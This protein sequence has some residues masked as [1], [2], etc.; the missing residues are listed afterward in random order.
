MLYIDAVPQTSWLVNFI[1]SPLPPSFLSSVHV[2]VFSAMKDI[3]QCTSGCKDLHSYSYLLKT[4]R[5]LFC[6]F[7]FFIIHFLSPFTIRSLSF[8]NPIWFLSSLTTS[9]PIC[10]LIGFDNLIGKVMGLAP[11]HIGQFSPI[12]IT[13][14]VN[15]IKTTIG[16]FWRFSQK[17]CTVNVIF[18]Y[19]I[20]FVLICWYIKYDNLIGLIM[21]WFLVRLVSSVWVLQRRVQ[22]ILKE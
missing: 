6:F 4:W 22:F 16:K 21:A 18:I 12:F 2:L 11:D 20:T 5:A 3:T 9:V 10:Y 8:T 14:C 17:H 19:L 7:F 1:I 13:L 15:Y